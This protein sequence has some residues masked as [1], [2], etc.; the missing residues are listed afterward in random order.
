[1]ILSRAPSKLDDEKVDGHVSQLGLVRH[2]LPAQDHVSH[3]ELLL[4]FAHEIPEPA[5][6]HLNV[7]VIY[8]VVVHRSG[9]VRFI[10]SSSL[11]VRRI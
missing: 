11:T 3:D 4:H 1:M 8:R 9:E 7:V 10:L 6:N 5:L 2:D